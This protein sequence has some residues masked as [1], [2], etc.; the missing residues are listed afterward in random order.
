MIDVDVVP[1]AHL[2]KLRIDGRQVVGPGNTAASHAPPPEDTE[3]AL[4][5][6]LRLITL[7][8][9]EGERLLSSDDLRGLTA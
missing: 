8:T 1:R 2:D 6:F 9:P 7:R 3:R 5:A 4:E